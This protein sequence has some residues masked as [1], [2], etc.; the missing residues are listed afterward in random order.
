MNEGITL[1]NTG[2]VHIMIHYN[3][4]KTY[5]VIGRAIR[6]C[7]HYKITNENN[8]FPEVKIY[9]YIIGLENELSSEEN[10]YES[11]I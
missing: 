5:Q 11:R 8:P 1:E 3:L 4:G 2:E 7:K 9:K 10:L 6:L